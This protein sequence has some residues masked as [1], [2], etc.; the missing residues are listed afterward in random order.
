MLLNDYFN[1]SDDVI[2]CGHNVTVFSKIVKLDLPN[3]HF[4]FSLSNITCL[5]LMSDVKVA[6]INKLLKVKPNS[7]LKNFDGCMILTF[8]KRGELLEDLIMYLAGLSITSFGMTLNE[9]N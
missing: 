9:I 7:L 1:T 5:N 8:A 2:G 6:M 3:S 4:T